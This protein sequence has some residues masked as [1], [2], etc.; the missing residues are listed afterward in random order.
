MAFLIYIVLA[1]LSYIAYKK[2]IRN[3][4]Y[5]EK[6]GLKF[7]KPIA[8]I[9]SNNLLLKKCSLPETVLAW[10]NEFKSEKIYGMFNFMKPVFIIRDPQIIKKL[11]VKDFDFFTDHRV[12][13]SEEVDPLFGK[14]LISL[15]GQKWKD[16]RSTLS[17][18]FTG[19]KM[20]L[21][22][23]FVTKVGKQTAETLKRQVDEGRKNDFEFKELATKFTVDNI[24]S[25]AFGISINSFSNPENDFFDIAKK[26]ANFGNTK[27]VLKFIGYMVMPSIMK[28][29]K[30]KVFGA[31]IS[32]FFK[33]AVLDTIKVREEKG[34]VRHDMINLLIQA[35][36][37]TL[38]HE[39]E[40][41]LI[42]G[43]ATVEES[44]MGKIQSKRKWDDEDLAAQAFIFF[45]ALSF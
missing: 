45:L 4:D 40:E 10:Y 13:I 43:F 31:K 22:F 42:E 27:T 30:I 6:K 18:A 11:A 23:D 17:P 8:F 1:I 16:M 15:Q 19:H 34:I 24:A 20:R 14:A 39:I 2:I 44:Q 41:K 35:K 21:M 28:F 25:C 38:V 37:G 7:S 29:F 9:G 33:E 32:K 36:K 12:I 26:F 3:H 5:F